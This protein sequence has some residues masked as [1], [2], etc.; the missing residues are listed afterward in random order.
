M[1]LNDYQNLS[2]RTLPGEHLSQVERVSNYAMGLS[3]EAGEVTDL[4]KK[5]LFHG[6]RLDPSALAYEL[7]D[8]LHYVAGL[9]TMHGLTLEQVATQ[10]IT[11]LAKR[12]PDGFSEEA[13]RGRQDGGD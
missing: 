8:V 13:S 12:Y 2:K 11:K 6:H 5:Q 7:G 3:G 4:L 10:N 9:A 1:K